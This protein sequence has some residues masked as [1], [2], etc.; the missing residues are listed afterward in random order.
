MITEAV[1]A[2]NSVSDSTNTEN[3]YA[4]HHLTNNP[5]LEMQQEQTQQAS[6]EESGNIDWP[7]CV[8]HLGRVDMSK[9]IGGWQCVN[10]HS[11]VICNNCFIDIQDQKCPVCRAPI[12][13]TLEIR[14]LRRKLGLRSMA[15]KIAEY[16]NRLGQLSERY[17]SPEIR[18]VY[19]DRLITKAQEAG[20]NFLDV[21]KSQAK[22]IV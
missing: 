6:L 22:S 13:N 12:P 15:V 4:C 3:T 11:T 10:K 18:N 19:R 8:I 9:E 1:S 20:R 17:S 14:S 16:I 5:I 21:L 2:R 7:T